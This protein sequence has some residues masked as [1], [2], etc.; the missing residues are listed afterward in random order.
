MKTVVGEAIF[1]PGLF[2]ILFLSFPLN[3]G[4]LGFWGRRLGSSFGGWGIQLIGIG[5][6]GVGP[7]WFFGVGAL[8]INTAEG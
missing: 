4:W 8:Y 7:S 1:F 2:F 3:Y 6:Y 5:A